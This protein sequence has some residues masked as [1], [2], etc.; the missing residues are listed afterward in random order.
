[1]GEKLFPGKFSKLK[2]NKAHT[3]SQYCVQFV[4]IENKYTL[5]NIQLYEGEKYNFSISRGKISF[6]SKFTFTWGKTTFQYK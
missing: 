3:Q 6:N 2:L 1:M 5:E 4:R